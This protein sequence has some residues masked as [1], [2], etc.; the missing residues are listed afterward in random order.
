MAAILKNDKRAD[1]LTAIIIL[2][3]VFV[4]GSVIYVSRTGG[5][6]GGPEAEALAACL[7]EKGA[8]MYGAY[9]CAHCNEQKKLFGAAFSMIDY[10]ECSVPGDP[11]EQVQ[12]CKD[13]GVD[14][15]P[16]WVFADDSRLSGAIPLKELADKAGC[17]FG[18]DPQVQAPASVI[19]A[20]PVFETVPVNAPAPAP[21][22]AP[23]Y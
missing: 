14:S 8:K 13:A 5:E 4:I 21:E 12:A 16:T 22:S 7:Q 10:V 6:G 15:Y 23:A 11:R 20:A 17:P 3:I 18:A 1:I 9:W 2:V 19:N